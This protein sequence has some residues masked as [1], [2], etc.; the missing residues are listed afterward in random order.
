M[1][2]H[3][4]TVAHAKEI[5]EAANKKDLVDSLEDFA[6]EL[7]IEDKNAQFEN[8]VGQDSLTRFDRPKKNNKNNRKRKNRNQRK[9]KPNNN[10]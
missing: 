1:N 3:K 8:V 2:W 4:I 5:I 6:E 7:I 9:R 10:A